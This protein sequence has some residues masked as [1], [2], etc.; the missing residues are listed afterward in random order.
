MPSIPN[1]VGAFFVSGLLKKP[2]HAESLIQVPPVELFQA[3][4]ADQQVQGGLL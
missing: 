4:P 1:G 3:G 2:A